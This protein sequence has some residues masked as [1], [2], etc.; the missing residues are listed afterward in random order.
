MGHVQYMAAVAGLPESH[1]FEVEQGS[2]LDARRKLALPFAR[3]L[4]REPENVVRA[5]VEAL[6]AE[7][8]DGEIVQLAFAICHF[9]TLNRL[10]EA[11]GVPLERENYLVPVPR[12]TAAEGPSRDA[13]SADGAP[14]APEK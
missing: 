5:D 1:V 12:P 2:R 3:K 8:T 7:F 6:K 4:T 14:K 13:P 9:N 10:A 11:F